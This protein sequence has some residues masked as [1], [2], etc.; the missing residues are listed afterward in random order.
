MLSQYSKL[1]NVVLFTILT[2]VIMVIHNAANAA[3]YEDKARALSVSFEQFCS[4]VDARRIRTANR[5]NARA[6]MKARL[7]QLRAVQKIRACG[8]DKVCVKK[9]KYNSI[10][11][12]HSDKM[13]KMVGYFS[14]TQST[15]D[16]AKAEAESAGFI[17]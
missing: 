14:W 8:S 15:L 4:N 3:S 7:L 16:S 2:V 12:M 11:E 9:A 13:L 10:K 5:Y 1:F 6:Y 17:E